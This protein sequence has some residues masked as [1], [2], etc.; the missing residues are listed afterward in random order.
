MDS[1]ADENQDL[2]K[3]GVV[4][5]PNQ[6]FLKVFEDSLASTS[7]SALAVAVVLFTVFNLSK[8]NQKLIFQK[9]KKNK[10]L[11]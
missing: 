10:N 11:I 6:A 1:F 4:F 5:K 9:Y 2:A 7:A 8:M 3:F